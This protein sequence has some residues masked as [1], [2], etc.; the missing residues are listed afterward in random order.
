MKHLLLLCLFLLVSCA[1]KVKGLT[2]SESFTYNSMMNDKMAVGG[3]VHTTDTWKHKSKVSYG[4]KL[5]AEIVEEVEGVKV[6]SAGATAKKLGRKAYTKVLNE[7]EEDGVLSQATIGLMKK[8]MKGRRY[9]IFGRIENDDISKNRRQYE[10]TNSSGEKTGRENVD[11]TTTRKMDVSFTV[12]DL[13]KG[14]TAWNGMITKSSQKKS[15]FAV[16]KELGLVSLVKAIKGS[17]EQSAADKY[18]YPKAPNAST[19]LVQTFKGFA[20]NLPEQD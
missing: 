10:E 1:T 8:K 12:V 15:T 3:I 2:K 14:E 19:I 5:R 18:P 7:I 20:E 4:N 17:E 9:V 16:K 13:M 11:A 6:S